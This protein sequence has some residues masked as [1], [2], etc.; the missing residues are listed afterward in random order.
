MSV[1]NFFRSFFGFPE[2]PP[3]GDANREGDIRGERPNEFRN[4]IWSTDEDDD[5]DD[6][7]SR[8]RNHFGFSVDSNPF[9]MHRFFEQQFDEMLRRFR[10]FGFGS[11]FGEG[12]GNVFGDFE[13]PRALQEGGN[14]PKELWE[15]YLKPGYDKDDFL[16]DDKQDSDLD[17]KIFAGEIDKFLKKPS[18]GLR[19]GRIAVNPDE[20]LSKPGDFLTKH[21]DSLVKPDDFL[22]K[23]GTSSQTYG[24]SIVS[25]TVR[26][27]DGSV[28]HHRTVKDNKGNEETTVTRRIGDQSYSVTT[29]T[30]VNGE[31]E[32]IKNF[33]NMD[34][35][36]IED[37][38]KKWGG[39]L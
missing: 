38:E 20:Y 7:R 36:H 19:L 6:F 22:V 21:D 13:H 30:K 23:P 18:V 34:E 31:K 14:R 10:S 17:G 4:P 39:K 26:R 5:D 25:K 32:F 11:I 29:K 3:E 37:F 28:E 15:Q 2:R 35:D 33:I 8:P 12:F 27:P 1:F 16:R 9:E 24:Q